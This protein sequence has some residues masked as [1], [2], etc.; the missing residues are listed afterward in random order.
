M[1]SCSTRWKSQKPRNK[2]KFLFASIVPS[3]KNSFKFPLGRTGSTCC[4]PMRLRGESLT[5]LLFPTLVFLGFLQH[6]FRLLVS[7]HDV[8]LGVVRLLLPFFRRFQNQTFHFYGQRVVYFYFGRWVPFIRPA[9]ILTLFLC[10]SSQYL[11][12]SILSFFS[13]L[14]LENFSFFFL[15]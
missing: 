5:L 12:S 8:L 9:S 14:S 10:F 13:P 4:S 7:P 15:D 2:C 3:P 11:I 6:L 1:S